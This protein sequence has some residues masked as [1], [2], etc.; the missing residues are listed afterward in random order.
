MVAFDFPRNSTPPLSVQGTSVLLS[1]PTLRTVG[2]LDDPT[3]GLVAAFDGTPD[4]VTYLSTTG[5]YGDTRVVDATTAPA[6]ETERQRLRVLAEEAVAALPCPSLVLRPAAIYGPG[7]GVHAAMRSGRFRLPDNR[8]RYVSRIHV[9]DLARIVASAMDR[10]LSGAFPVGDELPA[11][12]RDVARL[13]A[14][15]MGLEMPG[16]V[17]DTD[18]TETR[19]ADRRVDGGAVLQSLGL[20]LRYPTYREGVPACLAAERDS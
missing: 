18:L 17:A 8:D 2:G 9:E 12:S 16:T 1:I 5:V 7:R 15:L 10:R 20:R 4:H 19:R 6:P 14:N 3:P 11:R 13:C